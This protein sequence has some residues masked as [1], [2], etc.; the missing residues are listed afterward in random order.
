MAKHVKQL[1][2][3]DDE[4]CSKCS[5]VLNS[6]MSLKAHMRNV[7]GI[8]RQVCS[9]CDKAFVNPMALRVRSLNF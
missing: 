1:H 4:T 2:S 9:I 8:R 3:G 5:K 6:K 7:H